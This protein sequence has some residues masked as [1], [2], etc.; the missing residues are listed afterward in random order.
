MIKITNNAEYEMNNSFIPNISQS[1]SLKIIEVT[2]SS[3]II[4]MNNPDCRG[5]FPLESFQYWLKKGA[6]TPIEENI[7]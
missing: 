7:S 4:Q 6:L 3:V 1:Q 5:V 2:A